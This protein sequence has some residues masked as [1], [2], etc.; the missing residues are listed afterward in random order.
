MYDPHLD[1]F[2]IVASTGSFSKAAEY[3]Y[4]TPSAVI[5]QINALETE[6]KVPLFFRSNKGVT[7][8]RQGSYLKNEAV[9]YIRK[10]K[11]IREKLLTIPDSEVSLVLGT[12]MHEKCRLFYDFWVQFS[13][14]RQNYFVQMMTIDT[15]F[16][17]PQ[18]VDF[19]ESVRSFAPW[20][21]SWEYYELC[22][23]PFGLG[24][25][26]DHPLYYKQSLTY[27]DLKDYT[28]II[29][30]SGELMTELSRI[31]EDLQSRGIRTLERK[32]FDS[33]VV[34]DASINRQL[35]LMPVCFRD[36]LFDMDIK[37]MAW[38]YSISYG[39]LYRPELSGLSLSFMDF[40]RSY[41]RQHP[42]II[43]RLTE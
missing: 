17:I 39:L 21:D 23:S 26:K 6:L 25:A 8:T 41:H 33:D 27:E 13:G 29:Q 11:A 28:V 40:V 37:H 20:Q 34:W 24:A 31:R 22:R 19:I 38:D 16:P 12:S 2:L 32:G 1:T 7:L 14:D 36:V 18:E 42:E 15:S 9:D 3:L 10:G 35:V 4:I 5:Q 43:R 30:R